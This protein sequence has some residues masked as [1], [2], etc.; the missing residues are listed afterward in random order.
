MTTPN[1]F[2]FKSVHFGI[3]S[4]ENVLK[5]SVVDINNSKLIG[6]NSVYDER[7]GPTIITKQTCITCGLSCRLCTGHFGSIQLTYPIYHPLFEKEI[8]KIIKSFCFSCAKLIKNDEIS[9][10][11]RSRTIEK[12]LVCVNCSVKQPIWI[13]QDDS[14]DTMLS[15]SM[16]FTEEENVVIFTAKDCLEFFSNISRKDVNLI[17]IDVD[18]INL[19]IQVLPVLPPSTRPVVMVDDKYCDDDLTLQYVEIVKINNTIKTKMESGSTYDEIDKYLKMIHFRIS[20]LFNNSAGKS[21]HNTNGKTIKGIKE[22]LSSK[23]GL[24]RENLMGKRVEQSAR[25]VIGPDPTLPMNEIAIPEEFAKILTV[26]ERVTRYNIDMLKNLIHDGKAKFVKRQSP[27]NPNEHIEINLQYAL[28]KKGTKL[29]PNDIIIR[30]GKEIKWDRHSRLYDSDYI[31]RDGFLI[32]VEPDESREFELKIGDIVDRNLIE[33]DYAILNRQPTLHAGSMIAQKIRIIPGKTIR[34]NLCITKSLNADFDGDEGN[35]HI[36]Q[37]PNTIVELDELSSVKNH[38]LSQQNGNT[39]TVLVQDNL[40]SLYLMTS[41]KELYI[42]REYLFDMC[43]HLVDTDN[44]P[45]C[46]SRIFKTFKRLGI[47]PENGCSNIQVLSLCFPDTLSISHESYEI[48]NGLW[49]TGFFTKKV[50]SHLIKN[51]YLIYD[52]KITMELINNLQF[53]SNQWLYHRGFSIG[54]EDC[55]TNKQS[56][57]LIPETIIRCFTEAN[58]LKDQIYHEGIREIRVQNSLNKA[59]DIGL[60]IAKDGLHSNNNFLSTVNSGSKG[61]IF[62]IAQITGL[63]GQQNFRGKRIEKTMNHGRRSIY[64]YNFE[65][66][67]DKDIYESRG[68]IRHSFL[69]GLNPREAYFHALPG[70][71]GITDTALG[72]GETG[73][74]QR[75]IIKLMEDIHVA[76]DMTIRDEANQIYQFYYG[77]NGTDTLGVPEIQ[78]LVNEINNNY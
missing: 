73:Y 68:F 19:I 48:K 16:K 61:D 30:N 2:V 56:Q 66:N 54:L 22:R 53:I 49:I 32:S 35:L 37:K 45:W 5:M 1:N 36:A 18:P 41:E 20:S 46:I 38:I 70:R 74:M 42:S 28:F 65:L 34:F 39:N 71:E 69:R 21:K 62:N 47:V 8:I 31:I 78:D 29:L 3:L 44:K 9:N 27:R 63:L 23:N 51:V 76:N 40:T 50:M 58:Q 12:L 67:N 13:T 52:E 26:S 55:F 14:A 72:T 60:R 15:I 43:L 33:G 59:R 6:E 77:K 7:M 25:T 10:E 24:M 17:G 11:T 64:H 4:K 75:R 57:A